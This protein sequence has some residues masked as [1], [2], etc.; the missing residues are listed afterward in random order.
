MIWYT[1]ADTLTTQ[2]ISELQSRAKSEHLDVICIAE[3]FP[4]NSKYELP[5]A[6]YALNGY[7]MFK[8]DSGRF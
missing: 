8:K 5:D 3:T 4:Q 7:D 1:N 6:A 2:K